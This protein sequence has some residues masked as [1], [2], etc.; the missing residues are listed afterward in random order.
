MEEVY[1]LCQ[2][3][4]MATSAKARGVH[5]KTLRHWLHQA[6]AFQ[7]ASRTARREVVPQAMVLGTSWHL[8]RLRDNAVRAIGLRRGGRCAVSPAR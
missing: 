7:E 8:R 4:C 5:E 6:T 1:S 3:R 2:A